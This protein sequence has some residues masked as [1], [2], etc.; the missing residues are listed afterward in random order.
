[1]SYTT[2]LI[3]RTSLMMRFDT[4]PEALPGAGSRHF[5]PPLSRLCPRGQSNEYPFTRKQVPGTCHSQWPYGHTKL[6]HQNRGPTL[7]NAA[8]GPAGA[9]HRRAKQTS[10][11]TI[12]VHTDRCHR[13]V[14]RGNSPRQTRTAVRA[15]PPEVLA[16][17][18]PSR[19]P[20]ECNLPAGPCRRTGQAPSVRPCTGQRTA[21]SRLPLGRA[22]RLLSRLAGARREPDERNPQATERETKGTSCERARTPSHSSCSPLRSRPSGHHPHCA[23]NWHASLRNPGHGMAIRRPRKAR[24]LAPDDE[25]W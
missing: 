21:V 14:Q 7:G 19:A 18:V 15:I 11:G 4:W 12:E 24:G 3:P 9:R 10:S 16:R 13:P 8:E 23:G 25:E 2:R 6:R 22:N 1:M 17:L 5:S 20:G